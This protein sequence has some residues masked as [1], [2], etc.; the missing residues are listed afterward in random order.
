MAAL[1]SDSGRFPRYYMSFV[2]RVSKWSLLLTCLVVTPADSQC[3]LADPS[4]ELEGSGA[5]A[6]AGDRKSVV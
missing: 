2:V 1:L 3:M 4:F 6:F 5:Q